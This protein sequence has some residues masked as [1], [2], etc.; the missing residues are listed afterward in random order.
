MAAQKNRK[1]FSYP[2]QDP[3]FRLDKKRAWSLVV[4]DLQG[5]PIHESARER[6]EDFAATIAQ[7]YELVYTT[8][9]E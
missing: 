6:L 5:G 7:E 8:T 1:K 9:V 3:D 2:E 4:Y